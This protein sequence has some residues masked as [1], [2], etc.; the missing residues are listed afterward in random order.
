MQQY[1]RSVLDDNNDLV[2]EFSLE[3]VKAHCLDFVNEKLQLGYVC[4]KLGA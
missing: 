4:E 3:H 2:E 1:K